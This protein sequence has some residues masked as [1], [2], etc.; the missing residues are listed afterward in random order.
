MKPVAQ[1][2]LSRF[3]P[4]IASALLFA[5]YGTIGLTPFRL[6]GLPRIVRNGT[7]LTEDGGVHFSTPGQARTE[8]PPAWLEAAIEHSSI[9]IELEIL[10]AEGQQCGPARILSISR[11]TSLRNLTIAQQQDDLIVRLRTRDTSLNGEPHYIVRH[12]F[13]DSLFH[14]IHV[15][16]RGKTFELTLD[17]TLVEKDTLPDHPLANWDPGQHLILGN[18]VGGHRSWLGVV[19]RVVVRVQDETFDYSDLDSL[20]TPGWYLALGATPECPE[21]ESRKDTSEAET[22]SAGHAADATRNFIGFAPL[23]FFLALLWRRFSIV[24]IIA[25]CAVMSAAIEIGQIYIQGRN[26]QILDFVLNLLGG[27]SGVVLLEGL[28]RVRRTISGRIK[29]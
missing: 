21:L 28:D 16:I 26:P 23:G 8:R 13:A 3:I 9:D 20:S 6:E 25:A 29:G 10:S 17:G 18:E 2:R 5:L 11:S 27:I 15:R 14:T 4:L 24:R 19:R 7:V 22:R 1:A 12:V